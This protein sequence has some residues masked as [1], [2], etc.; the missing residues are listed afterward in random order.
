VKLNCGLP[1]GSAAMR[2]RLL[3]VKN[4]SFTVALAPDVVNEFVAV[5][6]K[7]APALSIDAMRVMVTAVAPIVVV[8]PT[9]TEIVALKRFVDTIGLWIVP[10]L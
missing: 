4:C 8:L 6:L 10:Q 2:R 7:N 9:A 3:R 5:S 1:F